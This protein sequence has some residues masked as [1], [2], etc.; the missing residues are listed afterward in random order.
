MNWTH[1]F[2]AGLDLAASNNNEPNDA[3]DWQMRPFWPLAM[4][5]T[6]SPI[7]FPIETSRSTPSSW[8]SSWI[9]IQSSASTAPTR[10]VMKSTTFV[11]QMAILAT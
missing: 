10:E 2:S 11:V 4:V 7:L 3:A 6:V 1:G 9:R 5:P 8:S